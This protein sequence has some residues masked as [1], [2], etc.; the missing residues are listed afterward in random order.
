[1]GL[2]DM[3]YTLILTQDC[4]LS[5]VRREWYLDF[6]YMYSSSCLRKSV[7]VC[8]FKDWQ[9][10]KSVPFHD[11]YGWHSMFQ[12]QVFQVAEVFSVTPFVLLSKSGPLSGDIFE[13][14]W[15]TFELTHPH[16]L[17]CYVSQ[18]HFKIRLVYPC[19]CGQGTARDRSSSMSRGMPGKDYVFLLPKLVKSLSNICRAVHQS[20]G[21]F[22]SLCLGDLSCPPRGKTF[23]G[24][25]CL[26]VWDTWDLC[27]P[28][29]FPHAPHRQETFSVPLPWTG[30][31][32]CYASID[33]VD[34]NMYCR[35]CLTKK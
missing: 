19:E 2:Q 13:I 24:S 5:S 10:S 15:Q 25:L 18:F 6:M 22:Y 31:R 12:T 20:P 34:S 1:M 9:H 3:Q 32:L 8:Q 28:G 11:K 27:F 17:I 33:S 35:F 21:D 14:G 30:T 4:R 16:V 26:S 29:R 7:Q 23:P